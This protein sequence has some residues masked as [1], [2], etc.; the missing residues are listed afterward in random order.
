MLNRHERPVNGTRVLLLGMAY[1]RATSDWRESP[2]LRVA[3][4]L[5]AMGA[6]VT[7]CDPYLSPETARALP[8]PTVEFAPSRLADHDLVVVLVDHPEFTAADI[9]NHAKLV[10]DAKG[11]LRDAEFIGE[12]L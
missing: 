5:V 3:E 11:I 7:A 1:K 2:S 4:Q 6:R 8:V 9:A 10:F 12:T